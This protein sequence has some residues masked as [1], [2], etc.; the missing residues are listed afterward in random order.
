MIHNRPHRELFGQADCDIC[1]KRLRAADAV[2]ET[3]DR[4]RNHKSVV[5]HAE[6]SAAEG[7]KL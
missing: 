5:C 6:C 1:G 4:S 2:A 3:Y 7:L